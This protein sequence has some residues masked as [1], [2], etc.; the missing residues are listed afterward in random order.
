MV[1]RHV[2][3]RGRENS[4]LVG[5]EGELSS[6]DT[7]ADRLVRQG[8]LH[9]GGGVGGDVSIALNLDARFS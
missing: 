9:V 8:D 6:I 1:L 3:I 7:N 5:L 4:I 2:T